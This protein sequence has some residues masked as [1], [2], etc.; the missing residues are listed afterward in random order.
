MEKISKLVKKCSQ[1]DDSMAFK[2]HVIFEVEK[3]EKTYK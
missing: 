1:G 2:F 3:G